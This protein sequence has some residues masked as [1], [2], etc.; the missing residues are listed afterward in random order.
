[1]FDEGRV[2]LPVHHRN[3]LVGRSVSTDSRSEAG[4]WLACF[5]PGWGRCRPH[6]LRR[7]DGWDTELFFIRAERREPNQHPK[8]QQTSWFMCYVVEEEEA[9]QHYGHHQAFQKE[10]VEMT[11][12]RVT[13]F[14]LA[15][16]Q[17]VITATRWGLWTK[18]SINVVSP[19]L[20]LHPPSHKT[21]TRMKK[22]IFIWKLAVSCSGALSP[23]SLLFC[24][25]LFA[26]KISVRHPAS[27]HNAHVVVINHNYHGFK[28]P[29]LLFDFK[30][31][32]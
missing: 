19:V 17:T 10:G 7:R 21:K 30:N 31:K 2:R 14:T 23:V 11:D 25:R 9:S 13:R 27:R 16:S 26:L 1:M 22:L 24:G 32:P 12:S 18:F 29:Q 15:N 6:T 4:G 3:S 20:R 8:M 5:W 28:K